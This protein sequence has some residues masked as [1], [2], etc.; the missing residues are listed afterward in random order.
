[1]VD[2][3]G[4]LV[5]SASKSVRRVPRL[6][7]SL[8][9]LLHGIVQV[10]LGLLRFDVQVRDLR[11]GLSRVRQAEGYGTGLQVGIVQEYAVLLDRVGLPTE[12]GPQRFDS[13]LR[14]G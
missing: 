13:L 12:R 1:S 11:R 10:P 3:P 4:Q 2:C 14:G 5:L 9:V 6:E 7:A 8:P